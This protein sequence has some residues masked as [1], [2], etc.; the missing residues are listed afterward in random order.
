MDLGLKGRK[1]IICGSSRGL[2]KACAMALA[3]EGCAVVINGLD[4]ERLAGAADEIRKVTGATVTPVRADINTE[5]GRAALIAACPDADILVNNN[6]GPPPGKF[7]DWDH[8]QWLQAIEANM[9]APIFM[10]KAVL[11][12]MCERKFGRIVNITSA[13]VKS[14]RPHMGLSTSCR[15]ALTALSKAVSRDVAADNVTINNLLPERIDTDRQTFMAERM[16]KADNITR[17]EARRRQAESL[18]AKR[19]GMPEEFG[20]ACAYLCS[21]QAGFISGQN[22]QLDG[23]AY[24]GLV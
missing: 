14:P 1:A 10:I 24:P 17:E 21:A 15:T 13:M 6:A 19:L 7:E 5:S 4:P 22:L 11:P 18:P 20:D 8:A 23:G 2:G 16:M 9:L 3:R 12:G